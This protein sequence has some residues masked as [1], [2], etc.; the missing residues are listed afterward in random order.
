M[1]RRSDEIFLAPTD[2]SNFLSCRHL[3]AFDLS[4][5]NGVAERPVRYGP[6]ID[7]LKARGAAHEEMYLQHLRDLGLTIV[8]PPENSGDWE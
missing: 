2:L 6:L 7:E 4:A 3:S 5:V 1:H 8:I